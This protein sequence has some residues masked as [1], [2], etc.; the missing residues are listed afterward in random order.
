MPDRWSL[1][2]PVAS[3]GIGPVVAEPGAQDPLRLEPDLFREL[4]DESLLALDQVGA[5]FAV[6]AAFE[7]PP[8]RVDAAADAIP[9]L[10]DHDA[11]AVPFEFARCGKAGQAGADHEDGAAAKFSVHVSFHDLRYGP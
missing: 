6:L 7:D 4:Q 5:G 10:D 2:H 9:R 3:G 8:H 11:R 1:P